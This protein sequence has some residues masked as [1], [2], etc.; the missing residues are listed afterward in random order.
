[1]L[2]VSFQ[3]PPFSAWLWLQPYLAP[4]STSILG[5]PFPLQGKLDSSPGC[6]T[7]LK[8]LSPSEPCCSHQAEAAAGCVAGCPAWL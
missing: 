8:S 3:L 7:L 4:S 5:K 1:M 2:P 6:V